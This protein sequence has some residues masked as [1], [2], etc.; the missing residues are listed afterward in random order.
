MSARNIVF[1]GI[2]I[3]EWLAA[4]YVMQH[5]AFKETVVMVRA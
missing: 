4:V 3:G 1:C 5:N 2:L